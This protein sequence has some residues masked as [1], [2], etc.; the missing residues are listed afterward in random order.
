MSLAAGQRETVG[1]QEME[2]VVMVW[3]TVTV[4]ISSAPGTPLDGRTAA[5][6]VLLVKPP[7]MVELEEMMPPVPVGW[8]APRR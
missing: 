3:S 7:P 6:V 2:V 4:V 1:A 8:A 5:E